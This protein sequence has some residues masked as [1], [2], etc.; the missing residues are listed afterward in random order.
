MTALWTDEQDQTVRWTGLWPDD[1]WQG[2][3]DRGQ[4]YYYTRLTRYSYSQIQIQA[5]TD[6]GTGTDTAGPDARTS[7]D[8]DR[9]HSR[10][11]QITAPGTG[12]STRWNPKHLTGT[13]QQTVSTQSWP[14]QEP[15]NLERKTETGMGAGQKK[16]LSKSGDSFVYKCVTQYLYLSHKYFLLDASFYI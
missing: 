11:Q 1:R 7:E 10:Q 3:G 16:Q 5:D 2:T 4:W 15:G 9:I 14:E 8:C 13:A 12:N 6:T